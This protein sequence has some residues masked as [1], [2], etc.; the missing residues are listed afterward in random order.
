MKWS[1]TLLLVKTGLLLSSL[2]S[3]YSLDHEDRES[4]YLEFEPFLWGTSTAAY[5][6]EGA[7]NEDGRGESIWDTFVRQPGKVHGGDT[8]EVADDSYHQYAADVEIMRQLGVN[9]YRFSL[10][11]S[12]LL[13]NGTGEVNPA[14]VEHYNHLIDSL[15]GAN[16]QPVVT[17][18]HWDLPQVLEDRYGGLRDSEAFQRDFLAYARLCF[19]L[20]NDRVRKWI[21]FNEPWSVAYNGY[22]TGMLAPGRCS[23]RRKCVAGNSSTEPYLVGHSMLLAHLAVAEVYAKEYKHRHYDEV[24]KAARRRAERLLHLRGGASSVWKE[25]LR[26]WLAGPG[27]LGISLNMDWAEPFLSGVAS[28]EVAASTRRDFQLAWFLDPLVL[29]NYPVIM[30]ER[31]G[32]RLPAFTEAEQSR[33][34]AHP[35]DFLAFNHYSSSYFFPRSLQSVPRHRLVVN[36]TEQEEGLQWGGWEA[37][38]DNLESVY[39]RMGLPIGPPGA[40]P[41]LHSV[42]W[43]LYNALLYISRR[44]STAFLGK[45]GPSNLPIYITEN[46]FDV[47]DEDIRPLPEVLNDPA[48]VAYLQSYLAAVQRAVE[49]NIVTLHGYFVWSLLDNFEWADGYSKRFGLVYVDYNSTHPRCKRHFKDSAWW[50]RD[51]VQKHRDS[52][53]GRAF[54]I[55]PIY[56]PLNDSNHPPTPP[57]P[58]VPPAEVPSVPTAPLPA[59]P[60]PLPPATPPA[61]LT[62]AIA[63][64][65]ELVSWTDYL[66]AAFEVYASGLSEKS[67]FSS[68]VP[69]VD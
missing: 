53:Q 58:I 32:S 7:W 15:I 31:V 60:A 69:N 28:H 40:S 2:V 64:E 16:I 8:G 5:Q 54:I 39:D 20:F 23:D 13:P 48:R 11:W 36:I 42:P 9:A 24:E 12:R 49:E 4:A 55:P 10:S 52:Y 68:V 37:D 17:L 38:Q 66:T 59:P 3:L 56:R 30:R 26:A 34:L 65:I 19:D 61:T 14:A 57:P 35:L 43:G 50:Y 67:S 25:G 51:Y 47:P 33:F 62:P 21:T 18:Y 22:G 27:M 41:W 1:P 29:G 63:E 44:Y 46:G 45:G 6:I